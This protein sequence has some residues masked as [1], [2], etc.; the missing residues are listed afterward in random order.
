M[1][2]LVTGDTGSVY[3]V[4]CTDNDTGLAINLTGSTIR[5]RWEDDAGAIQ[6]R[7]MTITDASNGVATYRFVAGEII[8][9][10]MKFENEIT[11]SG[12][13]ITSSLDL[14]KLI[15]REELG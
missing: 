8:A 10:F 2:D 4:T 11:D 14:E 13:F 6:T 7:I 1:T 12:G 3:Q 5:L 9:P 15:V